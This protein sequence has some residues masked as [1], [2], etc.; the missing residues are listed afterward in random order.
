[1]PLIR[2][3]FETTRAAFRSPVWRSE[4]SASM[5]VIDGYYDLNQD[6]ARWLPDQMAGVVEHLRA[7]PVHLRCLYPQWFGI[8]EYG[9]PRGEVAPTYDPAKPRAQMEYV[10]TRLAAEG[11]AAGSIPLVYLD[12]EIP[13][14]RGFAARSKFLRAATAPLKTL[15]NCE[16]INYTDATF[17][18]SITE[19]SGFKRLTGST[20]DRTDSVD[21]YTVKAG[22][23]VRVMRNVRA[24]KRTGRVIPH[25][26]PKIS[27]TQTQ[28]EAQSQIR[29][30]IHGLA[31][32]GIDTFFVAS[33][34][35]PEPLWPELVACCTGAA[36]EA[37]AI[38]A[39]D[40]DG[41][42]A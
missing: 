10:A 7:T 31:P 37:E 12:H 13:D 3:I 9:G 17:R 34:E 35:W 18:G 29:A 20:I 8:W 42:N 16:R 5:A 1:M 33:Y 4:R 21:C 40:D 41:V 32:R 25:L 30:M 38:A 22:D 14:P 23:L 36:A 11:F 28:A 27:P 2:V 6:P 26:P 24:C 39:A 19:W 15:L